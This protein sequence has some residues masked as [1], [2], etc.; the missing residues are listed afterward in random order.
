MKMKPCDLTWQTLHYRL[1]ICTTG[2]FFPCCRH[3]KVQGVF[4]LINQSPWIFTC[5]SLMQLQAFN[6]SPHLPVSS[7]MSHHSLRPWYYQSKESK[8]GSCLRTF[9]TINPNFLSLFLSVYFFTA[10][11]FKV[12]ELPQE[13]ASNKP[14][15]KRSKIGFRKSKQAT[16]GVQPVDLARTS[17]PFSGQM[18]NAALKKKKIVKIK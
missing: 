14:S 17:K 5:H 13:L 8:D 15:A 16:R 3:C 18:T 2:G 10:A 6:L 12:V 4:S 11:P 7:E 9:F 1:S